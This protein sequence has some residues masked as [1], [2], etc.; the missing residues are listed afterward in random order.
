MLLNATNA[1]QQ[2]STRRKTDSDDYRFYEHTA[3]LNPWRS[4]RVP[5]SCKKIAPINFRHNDT[6]FYRGDPTWACTSDMK[7]RVWRLA[8]NAKQLPTMKQIYWQ[9]AANITL[10][11][12]LKLSWLT[13]M[14]N[15][16]VH[17]S[18]NYKIKRPP[19]L[20]GRWKQNCK[21]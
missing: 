3:R 19:I 7:T 13:Y 8:D 1:L 14:Y 9:Q 20:P 18:D 21:F 4:V 10:C 2:L 12:R 15:K 6:N 17:D 5:V 16:L 11:D